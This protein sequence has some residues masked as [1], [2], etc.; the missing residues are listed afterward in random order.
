MKKVISLVFVFVWVQLANAQNLHF[1]KKKTHKPFYSHLMVDV[2]YLN[3]PIKGIATSGLSIAIA[4][5]FRDRFATGLTL[6]VTDSRS[7]PTE[8]GTLPRPNV[9]EYSQVSWLNEVILHPT[10]KL[11]FSFPLKLGVGRAAYVDREQFYFGKTLLS[12]EGVMTDDHFFVA[13]GGINAMWHLLQHIDLNVGGSYRF[14]KG[15]E[16]IASERDFVNYS[17]HIGL[18]MRLPSRN[19][20]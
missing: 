3:Y 9:F 2:S 13:E 14:T 12:R 16:R 18:R 19:R 1:D 17:F 5:V 20:H 4:P 8:F 15:A 11:D 6:D 7:M 10:R